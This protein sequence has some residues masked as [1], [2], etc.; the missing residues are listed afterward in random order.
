MIAITRVRT[1]KFRAG[2]GLEANL[3][4][5]CIDGFIW[6]TT[7]T[8]KLYVDSPINGTLQRTLINPDVAWND[9]ENKPENIP[10]LFYRTKAEWED[11]EREIS[12]AGAIYVYVDAFEINGASI[13]GVKIGDGLAYIIDLPYINQT[14]A[15][16]D[17]YVST[18][19][20][21]KWDNKVTAHY[22]EDESNE[23]LIFS[24]N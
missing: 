6:F 11:F 21:E 9:I 19:D 8:K 3:P 22:S 4:T 2:R 20:R 16:P 17:I 24:I 1:V 23:T 12:T 13:P 7:D 5:Q 10:E 15:N 18:E 14:E